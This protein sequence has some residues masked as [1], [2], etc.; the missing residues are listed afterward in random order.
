L[1]DLVA[2]MA[3]E[4][5]SLLEVVPEPARA[6]WL[7]RVAAPGANQVYFVP[8]SGWLV[9]RGTERLPAVFGPLEADPRAL[10]ER[11]GRIARVQNLLKLAG[12]SGG[13]ALLGDSDLGVKVALLRFDNEADRVGKAVTWQGRKIDFREG[14]VVGFR[15]ENLGR[16]P[17]D[18]TVLFLDSGFGITPFIPRF[19]GADN[20]LPPARAASG[21]SSRAALTR[22]F[23]VTAKTV[24]PEHLVVIAVRAKAEELPADFSFLA[25]ESIPR[26][27]GVAGLRGNEKMTIDSPLGRLFQ[28]ALYGEG[29][30]RGVSSIDI[31]EY[32]LGLVSWRTLAR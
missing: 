32:S 5:G 2:T 6:D 31:D 13:E 30:T 17:V 22:R 12:D 16:E 15:V 28:N 11:L 29:S 9:E 3:S 23:R 19:P 26:A 18:V 14:E 24:G 1:S 10:K 8:A 25:Q 7:V 21:T 4:A 27:R 20:R